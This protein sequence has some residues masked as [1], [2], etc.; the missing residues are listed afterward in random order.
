MR[1]GEH[2]DVKVFRQMGRSLCE[3]LFD[4]LEDVRRGE[5]CVVSVVE[6][7]PLGVLPC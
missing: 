2:A 3:R 5:T 1:S 6:G 4:M 7:S